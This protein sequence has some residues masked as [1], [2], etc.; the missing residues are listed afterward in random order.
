M[1]D[2]TK[3]GSFFEASTFLKR[4][5]DAFG[6][7]KANVEKGPDAVSVK[8]AIEI[9]EGLMFLGASIASSLQRI[10]AAQEEGV[11]LSLIDINAT[12]DDEVKARLEPAVN[13]E[14]EK[15]A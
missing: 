12:I 1:T 7:I 5:L 2:E 10:A 11:R 6:V 9:G 3:P 15:R 8:A 14:I 4:T 13:Q